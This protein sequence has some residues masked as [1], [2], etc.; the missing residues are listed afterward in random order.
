MKHFFLCFSVLIFFL[1][2]SSKVPQVYELHTPSTVVLRLEIARTKEERELGLM[3]RENLGANEGM[4]FIFENETQLSF[5]MKDTSLPLS[6]AFLDSTG[7]VINIEHMVPF[8]L[9]AVSSL[10]KAQYAIE[11]NRGAFPRFEIYTGTV[12]ELP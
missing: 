4:L 12:L 9:E 5:W 11:V 2:C 3:F 1:S 6:I 8:S 7:K 10:S